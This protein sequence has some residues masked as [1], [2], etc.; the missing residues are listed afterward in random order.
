MTDC[1]VSSS[2]SL[3]KDTEK[4]YWL[5]AKYRELEKKTVLLESEVQQLQSRNQELISERTHFLDRLIELENMEDED[6]QVKESG[7]T[8]S[9]GVA[10]ILCDYVTNGTRCCRRVAPGLKKCLLHAPHQENS[11]FVF[12]SHQGCQN[13]TVSKGNGEPSFCSYHRS[14]SSYF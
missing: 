7:E 1:I 4:Y 12:C 2:Y 10:S 14:V 3:T 8:A 13:P 5:K 6:H 11:G 9:Q